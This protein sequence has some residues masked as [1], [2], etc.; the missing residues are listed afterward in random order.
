[1]I[2]PIWTSDLLESQ[3]SL[4]PPALRCEPKRAR[5]G[6]SGRSL[7][8]RTSSKAMPFSVTDVRSNKDEQ[9][10]HAAEVLAR[11]E[12]RREVFKAVYFGKKQVKKRSEIESMTGL[13]HKQ[14]LAAGKHL[15]SN[16]L[17]EQGKVDGEVAY[18]KDAFYSQHKTKILRLA[19]NPEQLAKQPRNSARRDSRSNGT[20]WRGWSCGRSDSR[21]SERSAF[22]THSSGSGKS[23]RTRGG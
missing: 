12:Q 21:S 3:H 18:W 8:S 9:V 1:M 17:M 11:S 20:A 5:S 14:V 19:T 23:R 6:H 15:V 13:T 2:Y 16:G 22:R 10:A 4:E 7:P